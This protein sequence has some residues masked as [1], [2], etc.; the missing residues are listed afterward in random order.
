MLQSDQID[1]LAAALAKAQGAIQNPTKNREVEVR[2]K[3]GGAYKFSYATL[4]NIFDTIRAP[5]AD[6]GLSFTQT[7]YTNGDSKLRL[8]TLLMHESGQWIRTETPVQVADPGMQALGS[9]QTYARRYAISSLLGI[10]AD[11]D[12]DANAADGNHIEHKTDRKPTRTA[13]PRQEV[14]P[15]KNK[16]ETVKAAIDAADDISALDTVITKHGDDLKEIKEKSESA[17]GFLM[18]RSAKRRGVL[19]Q[20]PRKVA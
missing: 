9:A 6:N 16:V 14:E 18:D 2:T 4:D 17:Y 13:E 7:L 8:I 15:W 1:K 3:T 19:S 5:L 12:D 10:A 11:E 20:A